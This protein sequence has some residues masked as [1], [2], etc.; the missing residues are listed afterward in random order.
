MQVAAGGNSFRRDERLKIT[1]HS[2]D[3]ADVAN[4]IDLHT[5]EIKVWDDN[6]RITLDFKIV[7]S[8][9]ISMGIFSNHAEEY[10]IV[11]KMYQRAVKLGWK[12][13]EC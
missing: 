8:C 4:L 11:Y 1:C 3:L 13:K 7:P 6:N 2:V 9:N 12:G 10:S 5:G